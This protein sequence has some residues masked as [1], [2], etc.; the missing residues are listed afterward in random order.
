MLSLLLIPAGIAATRRYR[1]SA[2]IFSALSLATLALWP[3]ISQV[4]EARPIY[5][6]GRVN[7]IPQWLE[8]VE[9]WKLNLPHVFDNVGLGH[10]IGLQLNHVLDSGVLTPSHNTFLDLSQQV[11]AISTF[12]LIGLILVVI[13]RGVNKALLAPDKRNRTL[14]M[15][16]LTAL[17]SWLFTANTTSTSLVWFYPVEG[18]SIFYITLCA[19]ALIDR[20]PKKFENRQNWRLHESSAGTTMARAR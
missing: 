15:L 18:T 10:G 6:D 2:A 20:D 16:V 13:I 11:G 8:R 5:L 7:T 12:I 1:I 17:I 3:K 14:A 19:A 4:L 9:L